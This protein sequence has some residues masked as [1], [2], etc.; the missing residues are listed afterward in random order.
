ME[1]TAIIMVGGKGGGKIGVVV[2]VVVV[3][4]YCYLLLLLL[5]LCSMLIGSKADENPTKGGVRNTSELAQHW[6]RV[7]RHSFTQL[8][9]GFHLAEDTT[10]VV[11]K[12]A[13]TSESPSSF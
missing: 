7:R 10:S 11:L 9:L 1:S 2:V 12:S 13:Y 5:L 4:K 6:K 3:G 8:V